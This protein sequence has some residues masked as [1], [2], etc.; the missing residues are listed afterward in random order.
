MRLLFLPIGLSLTIAQGQEPTQGVAGDAEKLVTIKRIVV[1][2]TRLPLL[3]V[4]RLAQIKAGDQVNF[5]KLRGAMQRVT[6]SGLISNIDFEYES[7]PDKETDVVLHLKCNRREAHRQS[8]HSDF[9][10]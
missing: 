1:E 9:R 7:L 10:G 2:G 8:V 5:I 3:S 6:Q 4:I